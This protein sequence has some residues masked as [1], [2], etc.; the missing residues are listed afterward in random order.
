MISMSLLNIIIK[1]T[2]EHVYVVYGYTIKGM[3]VYFLLSKRYHG[4]CRLNNISNLKEKK[5]TQFNDN[6]SVILV[7]IQTYLYFIA[8]CTFRNYYTKERSI[9]LKGYRKYLR[10]TY[11]FP[12][13][14]YSSNEI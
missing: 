8:V 12:K 13:D 3:G 10:K 4:S 14:I 2:T 5:I 1:Y 9:H 7:L 6:V 11:P